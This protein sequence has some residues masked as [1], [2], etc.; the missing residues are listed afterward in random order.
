MDTLAYNRRAWDRCVEQ[1][2]RWTIPVSSEVIAS[3]RR[4]E[5]EVVLTPCKPVPRAWFP[6]LKGLDVLCLASGGG[7]QAPVLAAGG[8]AVTL[9]DNSPKQLAQDRL[10]ADRDDLELTLVEGDMRDLRG[11]AEE[12]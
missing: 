9:L 7:Q 2:D 11:F 12:S 5:W 4:G 6:D 3:A 8:A 10:V 1:G